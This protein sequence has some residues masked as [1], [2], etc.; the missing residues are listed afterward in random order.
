M[1]WVSL[2]EREQEAEEEANGPEV[3]W[4]LG[5]HLKIVLLWDQ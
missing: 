2:G 4:E 5:N 1:R 3:T